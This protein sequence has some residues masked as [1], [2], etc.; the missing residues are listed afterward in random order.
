MKK[1]IIW[2]WVFLLV[3]SVGCQKNQTNPPFTETVT[4]QGIVITTP[5]F[6]FTLPAVWQNNYT[7]RYSA[8]GNNQ[9][10]RLVDPVSEETHGGHYFTVALYED[11]VEAVE[12]CRYYGT[13]LGILQ[14]DV[15]YSAVVLNPTDLPVPDQ[16]VTLYHI[17][18]KTKQQVLNSFAPAKEGTFLRAG[19]QNYKQRAALLSTPTR[20]KEVAERFAK[21]TDTPITYVGLCADLLTF[22]QDGK[23][24]SRDYYAHYLYE[25]EVGN[26]YVIPLFFADDTHAVVPT[27]YQVE[28][29]PHVT[30]C[31]AVDPTEFDQLCQQFFADA[32]MS[33]GEYLLKDLDGEGI[34][35]LVVLQNTT[36][37]VYLL[38]NNTVTLADQFDGETG[39]ISY[40]EWYGLDYP[41]FFT[42]HVG[43][44]QTHYG[45]LQFKNNQLHHQIVVTKNTP[46]PTKTAQQTTHS[47]DPSLANIAT[48]T[49]PKAN[50]LPLV[51]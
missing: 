25:D 41:G 38:N 31:W 43:G 33:E 30:P 9:Y 34:P 22:E 39:T 21:E 18:Q 13:Y 50:F 49:L 32:N 28:A 15:T 14:G 42:C 48:Q 27:V 19:A 23:T 51:S 24:L 4:E 5:Y 44:G 47:N 8:D 29:F 12:V 11:P 26:N 35:E 2:L 6:S 7:I 17:L 40:Y 1:R 10:Y 3:F 46:D 45:Y 20:A 36:L 37:S 16:R